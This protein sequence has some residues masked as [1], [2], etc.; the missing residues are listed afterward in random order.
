[1][2]RATGRL[3]STSTALKMKVFPV[4]CLSDNYSYVIVGSDRTV[5]VI[6]PV[7]A[8]KVHKTALELGQRFGRSN[9]HAAD[10]L[11]TTHH[12]LDHAGGNKDFIHLNNLKSFPVVGGDNCT[13]IPGL[14]T[15]V[16]DGEVLK[17]GTLKI[18]AIHTPCHTREST[19]FYIE[20]L[21]LS[22]VEDE[23]IDTITNND[24]TNLT[25]SENDIKKAVFTG[26]TLFIAGCGRFFEG[27]AEEMRIALIEKL[28]SLPSD[29][30]IFCG[31]EY[32]TSNL[33]FAAHVEPTNKDIAS[34]LEWSQ[35]VN[36]TIPSTLADE[37]KTN[38]FM[39]LNDPFIRKSTGID[40][41]DS[42]K[43]A[44]NKVMD[45]LRSMKNSYRG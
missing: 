20:D 9:K 34:K 19:C 27:S 10:A 43:D 33:K 28:G 17:F 3:F 23:K 18:S 42:S 26:D 12:H 11:I 38:P 29:T 30:R 6:D 32:T 21:N 31:H 25:N 41:S 35:S 22:T 8:Q 7:N 13:E 40:I 39:R 4:N 44:L 24:R 36:K 14:N 1:M 37:F 2:Q 16:K 5:L 45:T 15:P